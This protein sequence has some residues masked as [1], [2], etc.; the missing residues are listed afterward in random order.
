MACVF[1]GMAAFCYPSRGAGPR[2][3]NLFGKHDPHEPL[4]SIGA[5]T[6]PAR[7]GS[8][9]PGVGCDIVQ[10]H[11]LSLLEQVS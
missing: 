11:P 6:P 4:H 3:T 1:A 7:R 2:E 10:R 9:V 8:A 5:L